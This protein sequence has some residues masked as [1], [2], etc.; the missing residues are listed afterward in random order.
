M[1]DASNPLSGL[2]IKDAGRLLRYF[3]VFVMSLMLFVSSLTDGMHNYYRLA[4][5]PCVFIWL[6]I[7]SYCYHPIEYRFGKLGIKQFVYIINVIIAT[8][9]IA[10]LHVLLLPTLLIFFGLM[11][12]TLMIRIN[13]VT[14]FIAP[15]LGIITF[16]SSSYFIF[17]VYPYFGNSTTE[18]RVISVL[19]FALFSALIIYYQQIQ[20]HI[21][22]QRENQQQLT[23]NNQIQVNLQLARFVPQ[24]LWQ[25]INAGDH[26]AKIN[27]ERRKLTVFFSDIQGFTDLSE[28]LIPED[29][30]FLLNDYLKHMT[31]IAKIYGGTVDKFMGDGILIFFGSPMT[32]GIR[33]DAILAVDMALAMRQQMRILRE[34]WIK[35]GFVDLHIRMG[36][37][38][39]YCHVGNYGTSHRMTYTI[40]GRDANLAAR[41]QAA[42][43]VDQ[44]L[45]SQETFNLVQD[46]FLCI[47]TAAM[48]LKG[49]GDEVH[50]WQV[51]ERYDDHAEQAQRFFDVEYK[52]FNLVLNLD[53]TPYYTY[54]QIIKVMEKTIER[55]KLQ[56]AQTDDEGAVVLQ[57]NTLIYDVDHLS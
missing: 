8:L 54:P 18:L 53:Q 33:D 27:Y 2:N 45:I 50:A 41:L 32:Q 23:L 12:A 42:A 38:T 30:A 47:K 11:L 35:M 19:A 56:Q 55:I 28:K 48:S 6:Y 15:V 39:G 52:G 21:A 46:K 26:H 22:M 16:Y 24:Q 34:R 17:G 49:I 14:L 44:I 29:L 20:L 9:F 10:A 37:A 3:C 40:I 43:A 1:N 4:L 13:V 36:L 25:Q 57:K 31:E 5:I 51:I 7:E